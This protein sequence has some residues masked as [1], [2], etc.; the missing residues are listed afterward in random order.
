MQVRALPPLILLL[1]HVG[2]LDRLGRGDLAGTGRL[3]QAAQPVGE[4]GALGQLKARQA[5]AGRIEAIDH[6]P[7]R[8]RMARGGALDEPLGRPG[9]AGRVD[10]RAQRPPEHGQGVQRPRLLA[11]G[12]ARAARPE[13]PAGIAGASRITFR[14]GITSSRLDAH[15][16]SYLRV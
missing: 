6:E 5:P 3:E 16:I 1:E 9:C 13:P 12:I 8:P 14:H 15:Y 2:Q 4:A 7:A 11:R 10:G